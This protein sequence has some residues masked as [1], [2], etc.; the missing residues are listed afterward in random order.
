VV[1]GIRQFGESDGLRNKAVLKI[2]QFRE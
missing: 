2:R 1:L